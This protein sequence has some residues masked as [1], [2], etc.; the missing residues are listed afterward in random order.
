M[1]PRTFCDSRR[2]VTKTFGYF[3]SCHI[4]TF[5]NGYGKNRF[6][7]GNFYVSYVHF[8]WRVRFALLVWSIARKREDHCRK[9]VFVPDIQLWWR[10]VKTAFCLSL[11]DL[12]KGQWHDSTNRWIGLVGGFMFIVTYHIQDLVRLG[13]IPNQ[14]MGWWSSVDCDWPY[15]GLG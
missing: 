9:H 5:W 14:S 11:F 7:I 10:S 3:T 13:F 12:L 4:N 6:T 1:W 15:P 8:S 2:F